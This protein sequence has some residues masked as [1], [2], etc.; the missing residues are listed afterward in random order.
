MLTA[1]TLNYGAAVGEI[2][3]VHGRNGVRRRKTVAVRLSFLNH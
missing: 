1:V 2:G 3:S